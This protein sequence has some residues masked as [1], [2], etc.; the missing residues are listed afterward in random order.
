MIKFNKDDFLRIS[1]DIFLEDSP[2]GYTKN[3][4]NLITKYL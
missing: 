1:K 3:V 2:T 4:I